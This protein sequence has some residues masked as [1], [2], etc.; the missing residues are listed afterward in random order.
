VAAAVT[1]PVASKMS[2]LSVTALRMT[3]SRAG[4]L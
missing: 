4:P 2:S 3:F 1:A